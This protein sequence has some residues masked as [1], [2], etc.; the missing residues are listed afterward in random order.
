MVYLSGNMIEFLEVYN[1]H[2]NIVVWG[3]GEC[4]NDFKD[5][6]FKSQGKKIQISYYVDKNSDVCDKRKVF[7]ID[8]LKLERE[9]VD[10]VLI[11]TQ[12]TKSVLE[13]LKD[14]EY[15]GDVLSIF[16]IVYKQRWGD[17][18]E[19]EKHLPDLKSILSDKKSK[20]IVDVICKK[21]KALDVDYT[22]YYEEN[23][24]F[25]ENII[26]KEPHAIFVDAGAYDGGTIDEFIQFQQNSFD[27]VL[28]FEMNEV[29][30]RQILNKRYDERVTIYNK[31]LW[32]ENVECRYSL[33]ADASRLGKGDHIAQCVKLDEVLDGERVTFI[34][35]DI[36]GAEKR[37]L[38]GAEKTI[39]KWK[40]Q[41][42]ICI[43]HEQNDLWQIPFLIHTM[44]P[45]YK[46]YV[47]HH[48]PNINETVLYA[49]L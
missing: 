41:L 25:V 12:Y 33:Q 31:G 3:A 2:S 7:P 45:E 34:K 29:N 11:A 17:T 44:V 42:A 47:R 49:V 40:P 30:Y 32:N 26:K 43:Y 21:R 4:A 18:E 48:M 10:L 1:N 13:K 14:I 23:Q 8:R 37:A 24:Y 35:M 46:L 6:F 27:K 9:E 15:K 19:I 38:L 16:N 20:E 39:K 5:L 28:S 22:E 36:E